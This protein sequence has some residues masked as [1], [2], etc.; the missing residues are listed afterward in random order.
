MQ[1]G[2]YP[3]DCSSARCS[4]HGRRLGSSESS[5]SVGPTFDSH[6]HLSIWKATS[7]R[8]AIPGRAPRHGAPQTHWPSGSRV[9]WRDGFCRVPERGGPE[10]L[11]VSRSSGTACSI[12]SRSSIRSSPANT[13]PTRSRGLRCAHLP[14]SHAIP[15]SKQSVKF[16]SRKTC[17]VACLAQRIGK[18]VVRANVVRFRRIRLLLQYLQ[19]SGDIIFNAPQSP[20][21]IIHQRGY[22]L[23]N[24]V[25]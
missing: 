9:N 1:T 14:W 2:C 20:I 25:H 3:C 8:P 6:P 11:A 24:V 13:V 5:R 10:A 21:K 19:N 12:C 15:L 4:P 17:S 22:F 23:E 18:L 16:C 7:Q